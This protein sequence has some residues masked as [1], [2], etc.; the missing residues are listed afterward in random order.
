MVPP[1]ELFLSNVKSIIQS[2]LLKHSLFF[3]L[4]FHFYHFRI[5]PKSFPGDTRICMIWLPSS[6][7]SHSLIF[8]NNK[9]LTLLCI[10]LTAALMLLSFHLII[11]PSLFNIHLRSSPHPHPASSSQD[12]FVPFIWAAIKLAW[13]FLFVLTRPPM[14]HNNFISHGSLISLWTIK[15]KYRVL[16]ML[17]SKHLVWCFHEEATQSLFV[18]WMNEWRHYKCK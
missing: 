11:S 12:G 2:L 10:H 3:K 6:A 7:Q 17:L 5:K 14:D 13:L 18:K 16:S 15:G 1:P 4:V 9:L 8:H